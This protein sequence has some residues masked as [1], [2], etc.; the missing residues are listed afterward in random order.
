MTGIAGLAL[1]ARLPSVDFPYFFP[2]DST[3]LFFENVIPALVRHYCGI[4]FKKDYT[5]KEV[6][7]GYSTDQAVT[8]QPEAGGSRK[9]KW[10]AHNT[11]ITGATTRGTDTR[12]VK[13]APSISSKLKFKKLSDSWNFE[14][15]M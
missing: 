14:P 8:E 9:R 1:L 6:P 15:S 3:H 11:T 2:S 4:F 10:P 13:E 7:S 5:I 12:G